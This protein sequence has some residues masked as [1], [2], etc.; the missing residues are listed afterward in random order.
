MD[1]INRIDYR[2][3]YAK[4]RGRPVEKVQAL[5][6]QYQH[7]WDIE[8]FTTILEEVLGS[9]SSTADDVIDILE[10]ILEQHGGNAH[11]KRAFFMLKAEV[12][13][14]NQRGQSFKEEIEL[15][16]EGTIDVLEDE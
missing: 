12:T 7:L 10:L 14:S 13:K 1:A 5:V 4:V 8:E 6:R 15:P 9:S 11:F 2:A 16:A 3:A